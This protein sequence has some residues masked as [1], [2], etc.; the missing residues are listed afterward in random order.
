M[1]CG[2]AARSRQSQKKVIAAVVKKKQRT[3]SLRAYTAPRNHSGAVARIRAEN[4]PTLQFHTRWA[5]KKV[6]STVAVAKSADGDRTANSFT[7][8]LMSPT[9]APHQWNRGGLSGNSVPLRLGKIQ[10]PLLTISQTISASLD[11]S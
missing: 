10:P 4:S 2:S 3:I 6:S 1:V 5:K 9:N 11:S 7:L 8:P